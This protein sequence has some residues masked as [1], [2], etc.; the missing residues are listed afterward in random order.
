M[1]GKVMW[2]SEYQHFSWS[3]DSDLGNHN[4]IPIQLHVQK[5]CTSNHRNLALVNPDHQDI[6]YSTAEHYH[7]AN[8]FVHVHASS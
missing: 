2:G 4:H 7:Y 8:Y 5:H 3:T 1:P 6:T